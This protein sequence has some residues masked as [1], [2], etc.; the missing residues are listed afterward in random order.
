MSENNITYICNAC[1][2]VYDPE[3]G[4]PDGGIAP[5]TSWE[6]IPDDWICPVCGVGKEDFECVENTTVADDIHNSR[7]TQLSAPLVIVGSGLAGYS[8]VKEL[9]KL[10]S[11]VPIT[12]ITADGGEVYTKPMLSNAF[13]RKHQ[14]DDMIQKDASSMAKDLD[15]E[16]MTHTRVIAIDRN[17]QALSLKS[18]A[19]D[20]VLTYH[21]LVLALGADPRVFPVEG[22]ELVD[23]ATVNDLDDYRS[24]REKLTTGDNI[25]LIGA[26]LIGCEFAN[27]MAIAGFHITMVDPAA[28]PLARLL[29]E[30]LGKMLINALEQEDCKLHMGCTVSRY[31]SS[32]SGLQAELDNGTTIDFD[33]VLSA[34]GLAPRIEL[35]KQAGLDTQAGII[36]DGFMRTNDPLIFALGDCAQTEAGSLPFIAPLLAETRALAETLTGNDTKLHLPAM[37]VVVKTPALPLIVCP[38]QPGIDGNWEVEKSNSEAVAIYRSLN[39][40]EIGFA[41]AGSKTALHQSM[42]KRMPDLLPIDDE[43]LQSVAED[44]MPDNDIQN[45]ECITCGYI[46]DP[47]QGDPDG[48]IAP[49]TSW[50]DIPDDWVCPLCGAGKE[51]F[52]PVN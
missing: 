47:Q 6:D 3:Q 46:Y 36:V 52:I 12:L 40:N 27:D 8:L 2:W 30:D 35:A 17:T 18:D 11:S 26:G 13:A 48:G 44:T 16:I 1:G 19:K 21:S 22:Q 28:W 50:E 24:W 42:A 10:D 37:P 39:A 33:H 31:T 14:A 51:D 7:H 25:L 23:I 45:Y 43:N 20:S 15:I 5:G 41:L 29:P 4:D 9:R 32:E 34:V 38:P 49:G